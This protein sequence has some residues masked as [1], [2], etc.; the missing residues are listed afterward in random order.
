MLEFCDCF[1]DGYTKSKD[2]CYKAL[3]RRALCHHALRHYD[4]ALEDMEQAESLIPNLPEAQQF[5]KRIL[6][7][8]QL[9]QKAQLLL[10]QSQDI[11]S[12]K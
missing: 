12:L 8:K 9:N 6:M 4:E 11:Q 5:T 1:E 7:D 10:Q 2:L 3:S